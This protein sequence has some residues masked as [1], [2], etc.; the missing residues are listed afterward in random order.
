MTQT[1]AA[2]IFSALASI[3]FCFQIAL[4]LGAPWGI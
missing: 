1:V 4:V 3:V 2:F